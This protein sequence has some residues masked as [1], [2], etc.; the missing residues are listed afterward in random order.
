MSSGKVKCTCGWSWN[1]SDSSKKDMYICHECGRDNSNNM[2][3]GGWLD[4]YADGGTMQEHQENY[5]DASV[6]LPEGFV[7]MG[8]DTSGRNYSPA[9][10]G[11]F[12]EGGEIDPRKK[13]IDPPTKRG[14]ATRADSLA[15][16]NS[17]LALNKFYDK[18][19]KSG[20]IKKTKFPYLY[21]SNQLKNEIK[22]L[23]KE[24]LNFYREQIKL[25][26]RSGTGTFDD[27]YKQFF[28]L[29][30]EQVKKLE[31]QGLGK[32]KS[33]NSDKAYYRD[34]ITPMQNLQAPFALIDS[35]I[36]PQ[37]QIDYTSSSASYPGG[38]VIVYDY[39]PLAVT[40]FDMLTPQQQ[41]LRLEK[42]GTSGVPKSYLDKNKPTKTKQTEKPI[43]EDK[44]QDR[45]P[46]T[47]VVNNLQP[48]GLVSDDLELGTNFPEL[49]PQVRPVKDWKYIWKHAGS[50]EQGYITSPEDMDYWVDKKDWYTTGGGKDKGD[51]VEIIPQYQMGGYV[52]PVNYVPQ[53]QSGVG[54]ISPYK[55]E[56]YL[57][58]GWSIM[59]NPLTAF[60]Y[61]ARNQEIPG[62]LD[63]GLK[64]GHIK[65]N[66]FDNVLDLVN[67]VYYAN[68]AGRGV[69]NLIQGE[70]VEFLS[71]ALN[72]VPAL[73]STPGVGRIARNENKLK[74]F[75]NSLG[76]IDALLHVFTGKDLI[77]E[78]EKA[79]KKQLEK[80]KKK[81]TGG[82]IPGAV[83]FSYARVGAP[84]KGPRR[85]Q[86]DVTDASA[87]NGFKFDPKKFVKDQKA[88]TPLQ[89]SVDKES[90]SEDYRR[91]TDS[92]EYQDQ[93]KANKIA[94][95]K[96]ILAD[97]KTRIKNSVAAQKKPF[98]K[99]N[100]RQQLADET[101]A[102]GDKF[103]IFPEDP[104]SFIDDWLNP[105]VMI[106]N[107]ASDLGS[108][109]LRAQQE[110]SYM[111]Y[112]TS[113]GVPLL[114]GGLEGIGA[115]S[116]KQFVNNLVNP[117]N[118][119]PGYNAAEKYVGK[120]INNLSPYKQGG[121]IKDDRGQWDHPGEVTE[122]NS[123]EITMKPDPLTGK[124]LTRPL[125]GISDTG[126]VKIMKPGKDYKF[127]GTKVTEYPI[128]QEGKNIKLRNKKGDVEIINTASPEY[129]K[130]YKE[131]EIQVPNAGEDDIPMFGGELEDVVIKGK[132]TPLSK[133]RAEYDKKNGREAF[134]NQKKDEYIKGLGESNWFGIDRTNFP[135]TVLRDINANYDY[136]RNTSALE[137]LAEQRGFDLNTRD[138]WI[139]NLTPGEREALINSKY[140]AQ[141]NPNEFAESLSGL[142][143]IGNTVLPGKP[144][145]FPIAGLTPEEEEEDRNAKLSG[146]KVFAPLNLPGNAAANYLKNTN[147]SSYGDFRETP[148]LG[149]QRMGNVSPMESMAFNP[150]TYEAIPALTKL[151]VK[152]PGAIADIPE[153]IVKAKETISE[154]AP[155][156]KQFGKD[157]RKDVGE[158]YERIKYLQDVKNDKGGQLTQLTDNID[159][160]RTTYDSAS[161]QWMPHDIGELDSY[162][163]NINYNYRMA[164]ENAMEPME[165]A[166]QS[167]NIQGKIAK[168]PLGKR[169]QE[170]TNGTGE[171]ATIEEV[172][173]LIRDFAKSLPEGKTFTKT[174]KDNLTRAQK[175]SIYNKNQDA[176]IL[177]DF[178]KSIGKKK[179][180]EQPLEYSQKEKETIAAIRELGKYE[181]VMQFQGS[182]VMNDPEAL[183]NINK[184]ILKLDDTVVQRLLGVTKQ[185]LLDKYKNVVPATKKTQSNVT[186]NP[187]GVDD[188]TEVD[189]FGQPSLLESKLAPPRNMESLVKKIGRS[190]A[191][192]FGETSTIDYQNPTTFPE[193][194]IGM[195]RTDYS[196]VQ[197]PILG[198]DG[199]PLNYV[200]KLE[201]Q[202]R[203]IEQLKRALNKVK[204]SDKGTNFIGSGSLSTDSYP[205]TLDAGTMM[206]NKGLVE[207][208]VQKGMSRLNDMGYTNDMPKL[209]LKDI[210]SKIEELEK[211]SGK[212]LPRA[213]FNK[214]TKQYEVPQIY[215]T[216]LK[217][218]GSIN[219]ADENSLVKLDQLTNFTNYNTKQP[220]GWLDKYN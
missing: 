172:H 21:S 112:A 28:N 73:R 63:R 60:G 56:D 148:T 179:I 116:N 65:R 200:E 59:S 130:I 47:P 220:G 32:T 162:I 138:S 217:Q 183:V 24:N 203:T 7:G 151:A 159:N 142:Q 45:K 123:N 11:Q 158:T 182:K 77:S 114:T 214:A 129:A 157:V 51:S 35:R 2:K 193:S 187:L 118:T 152:T 206:M 153:N 102:T 38:D 167:L 25:R 192:N 201:A 145:N 69:K 31:Y 110:D 3:N 64:G 170:I 1:K 94:N 177:K 149:M 79:R 4:Q 66:V 121:V 15:V 156:V 165:A 163:G 95:D 180:P 101:Q 54:N 111:P 67:P 85:N 96:A 213:K 219:K 33:S 49:R 119:I 137:K 57:D 53:A 41:K 78:A 34:M 131:G 154:V 70:P 36:D 16:L 100:W 176:S 140:S 202:G 146:L 52:Y 135:E 82:S 13:P 174:I 194:L 161:P 186:T 20:R 139:H 12:A 191:E 181:R 40:P 17:Q 62:Y 83:G 199:Y 74:T 103:R 71:E 175:E 212:K 127:K 115:K 46:I 8:N 155:K 126:D 39:D 160:V 134:I 105:G 68:S 61:S 26:D 99:D 117:F 22:D 215:F 173:S 50:K 147:M 141:L 80:T 86:T 132:S 19:V 136:D 122:I 88:N 104:D 81:Q 106:G 48:A 109:P 178:V 14:A 205:L 168:S 97:R 218:G 184:E 6:S 30:P 133:A 128:A 208:N 91:W 92:K 195:A 216:R 29:T 93:V 209:A 113:I 150:L 55:Q 189:D 120:K 207:V 210:N 124:K 27:R 23:N 72:F 166:R 84:S 197:K 196:Y 42:Y 171:P 98:T 10:G 190:Y 108:A 164:L 37:G 185:E 75:V 18:E 89:R 169:I 188:L 144:F 76:D 9:W 211:L 58:R 107:M 143:Q 5:N 198:A 90:N 87:Q 43:Y 125:L 44:P 204:N